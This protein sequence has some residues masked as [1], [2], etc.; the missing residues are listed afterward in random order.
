VG[1]VAQATYVAA[2]AAGTACGVALGF[3]GVSYV[4]HLGL[5]ESGEVPLLLMMLGGER[6]GAAD[7][8]YEIA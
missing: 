7:F 8:R 2:T 6:P 4:E 3:D 5:A 1:A